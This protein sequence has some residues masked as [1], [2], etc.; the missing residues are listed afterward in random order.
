MDQN[1]T[2]E[3][4][5]LLSIS[6]PDWVIYE[7]LPPY[8]K[9]KSFKFKSKI[10]VPYICARNKDAFCVICVSTSKK[11]QNIECVDMVKKGKTLKVIAA[12]PLLDEAGRSFL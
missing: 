7:T 9:D 10:M 4:K 5:R 2:P 12:R 8:L 6:D 3:I 11:G 1:I